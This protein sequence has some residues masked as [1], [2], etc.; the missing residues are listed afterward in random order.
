V[1]WK[2]E[3][4]MRELCAS[5]RKLSIDLPQYGCLGSLLCNMDRSEKQVST[6]HQ[7]LLCL[8]TTSPA[9]SPPKT[10]SSIHQHQH[11]KEHH[12]FQPLH[13]IPN[14]TPLALPLR[15]GQNFIT[16][17]RNQTLPIRSCLVVFPR[18]SIW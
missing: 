13:P 2:M 1:S 4:E 5:M 14:H 6:T 12:V 18:Q 7:A 15:L 3:R 11:P 17:R 8:P 10:L 9:H 16:K